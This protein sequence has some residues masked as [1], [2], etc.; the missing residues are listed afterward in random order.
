MVQVKRERNALSAGA[1]EDAKTAAP[2]ELGGR[3]I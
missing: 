1:S 2:P 3:G